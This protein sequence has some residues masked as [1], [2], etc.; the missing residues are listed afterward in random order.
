MGF[1]VHDPRKPA[2][3]HPA[4]RQPSDL[5]RHAAPPWHAAGEADD[6][7]RLQ[8]CLDWLNRERVFLEL[9]AAVRNQP[10]RLPRAAQLELVPGIP[11]PV[12]APEPDREGLPVVPA[13]PLAYERL[14]SPP[15]RPRFS[16]TMLAALLAAA[17][18]GSIAYRVSEGFFSV[19]GTAQAAAIETAS[20]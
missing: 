3:D 1:A 18:A 6:L 15:E 14:Q 5:R 7:D 12:K 10:R 2:V 16:G 13:P 19:P 9:E 17:V 4:Q 8:S 11:P 20:P